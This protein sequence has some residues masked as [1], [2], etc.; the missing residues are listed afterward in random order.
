[1]ERLKQI[2]RRGAEGLQGSVRMRSYCTARRRT[3]ATVLSQTHFP[4]TI[5]AAYTVSYT[6]AVEIVCPN[7]LGAQ[8]TGA[9]PRHVGASSSPAVSQ[10]A[11]NSCERNAPL[12]RRMGSS[13]RS[14]VHQCCRDQCAKS[15]GAQGTY[16]P[17]RHDGASPSPA[18][19]QAAFN[20]GERNAPIGRR[21]GNIPS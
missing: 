11:F 3:C 7:S 13:I 10:A 20:T 6:C 15:L 4:T 17:L 5:H 14:V 12:G 19:S 18:V 1:M 21:T 2:E 16:A 8:G 9:L